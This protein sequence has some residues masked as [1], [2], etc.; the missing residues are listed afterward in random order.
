MQEFS[1]RIALVDFDG[2]PALEATERE[3]VNTAFLGRYCTRVT[4]AVDLM[5]EWVRGCP[6]FERIGLAPRFRFRPRLG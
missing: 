4:S 5:A 1:A 6:L 3:A 2:G